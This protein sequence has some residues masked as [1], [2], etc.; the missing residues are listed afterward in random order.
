MMLSLVVPCGPL[1]LGLNITVVSAMLIGAGSVEVSAR[2][3]FP[4]TIS[5]A[6][7]A[8]MIRSCCRMISVAFV[9]EMRGS[10]MGMNIAVSSSS[11]GMNSEPMVVA[12]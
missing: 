11:G 9:S 12:V 2:P 1:V 3:I 10:V 5:T 4:T 6:G 8:A 7:S